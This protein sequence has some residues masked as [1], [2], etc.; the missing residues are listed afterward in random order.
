V[1]EDAELTFAGVKAL[2]DDD[3]L[4]LRTRHFCSSRTCA[5]I[6]AY[7]GESALEEYYYVSDSGVDAKRTALGVQRI[8]TPFSS[9][10]FDN[11]GAEVYHA[12][13]V[14]SMDAVRR[15]CAPDENP[16]DRLA[17]TLGK[18][19]P[20]GCNIGLFPDHNRPMWA[21]IC[22]TIR[23]DSSETVGR[24]PHFDCLPDTILP[25]SR[26]LSANIYVKLPDTG[27]EL[28]IWD[29]PEFNRAAISATGPGD[30]LRSQLPAPVLVSPTKC[31]L[32]MFNTRKPHA[33]R[34]FPSGCRT[35]IQCF[36]GVKP[37]GAL[38]LWS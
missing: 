21:G 8:G 38:V 18:I 30:D 9:T 22:R 6:A 17:G 5:V 2:I 13:A 16:I 14:D 36:I 25:L 34:S 28:E 3:V 15:V 24:Q 33:I 23:A 4:V 29:V 7:V 10:Y 31:E 11:R 1:L 26:Q 37:D 19:W 35:S 12:R 27:G 20:H 32:V